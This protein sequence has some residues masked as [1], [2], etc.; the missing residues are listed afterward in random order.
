MGG[1]REDVLESKKTTETTVQAS[2][3]VST[4]VESTFTPTG[5][6][7]RI[8]QSAGEVHFHDDAG[9]LKCAVSVSDYWG[10]WS[11]LRTLQFGNP[12]RWS[13]YDAKNG[14]FLVIE[15]GA[16]DLPGTGNKQLAAEISL[17]PMQISGNNDMFYQFE[18]F[19][20]R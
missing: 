18:K 14:T 15:V 20:Q 7:I 3:G 17:T 1:E 9:R 10:A 8:H 11:R 5:Q 16:L 19:A 13:Y 4:P 2:G 6:K 12:S